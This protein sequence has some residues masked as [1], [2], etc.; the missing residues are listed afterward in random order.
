MKLVPILDNE[1]RWLLKDTEMAALAK[2]DLV[3]DCP[4]MTLSPRGGSVP[5][6]SQYEGS[7][8]IV[9]NSEGEGFVCRLQIP[10]SLSIDEV[11]ATQRLPAGTRIPEHLIYDLVATDWRGRR[12]TAENLIIDAS[13][14]EQS[15]TIVADIRSLQTEQESQNPPGRSSA[16]ALYWG[17]FVIPYRDWTAYSL[18]FADGGHL[19][20]GSLDS[21]KMTLPDCTARLHRYLDFLRVDLATRNSEHLKTLARFNDSLNF[22]LARNLGWSVLHYVSDDKIVMHLLGRIDP[23]QKSR[24]KAPIAYNLV[25]PE[26]VWRL[27]ECYYRFLVDHESDHGYHPLTERVY[28][29]IQSGTQILVDDGRTVSVA[30][31]GL[32]NDLF[33]SVNTTSQISKKDL[34]TA[35]K[36]IDDLELEK[37]TTDRFKTLLEQSRQVRAIDRLYAMEKQDLIKES[38]IDEWKQLRN[39]SSHGY[40]P[41]SGQYVELFARISAVAT[42]FYQLIFLAIEYSGTYTNYSKP[43]YPQQIFQRPASTVEN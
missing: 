38:L 10:R 26:D 3:I 13:S 2:G 28:S 40:L 24:R 7:G 4:Q 15:T 35:K 5:Q 19:D 12:W 37:Q 34:K 27:F 16:S 29:V 6:Q 14:G 9:Q 22:V 41:E 23:P 11:F 32:V 1:P 39:S 42:L 33:S 25:G 21:V 17:D 30:V 8:V 18:K 43:G 20:S 31:E 36:A